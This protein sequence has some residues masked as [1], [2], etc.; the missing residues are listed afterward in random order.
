[1]NPFLGVAIAAILLGERL[2]L[3]DVIG[4]VIIACGIL[5]VQLSKQ[6]TTR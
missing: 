1:M 6:P 3:V 4:V 2:S 5:A